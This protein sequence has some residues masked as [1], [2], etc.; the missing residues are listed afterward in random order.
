VQN[1]TLVI[2][3]ILNNGVDANTMLQNVV[4]LMITIQFKV[5]AWDFFSH[6]EEKLELKA[7]NY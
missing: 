2:I 7:I 3:L 4:G 6:G 5:I 1:N